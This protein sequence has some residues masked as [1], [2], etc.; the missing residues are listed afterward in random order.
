MLLTWCYGLTHHF[1]R[2]RTT[3]C[4]R[5]ADREKTVQRHARKRYASERACFYIPKVEETRNF[6]GLKAK[7]Y[8]TNDTQD[9]RTP[10]PHDS[11]AAT[12][13]L[14]FQFFDDG[15]GTDMQH[16]S[17]IPNATGVHRHVDDLLL[18]LGGVTSVAVIQQESAPVAY[19]LLAR[20][21]LLT[22]PGLPMSDDI[23]PLAIG[24]MQDLHNHAITRL[25]WGLL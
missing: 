1:S 23:G 6:M 12:P 20:I 9:A 15:G 5:S 10:A 16:A 24:A 11:L 2:P 21:A 13:A 8:S 22:L 17:G 19:R 4:L 3:G 7:S 25:A 18:D 14:F